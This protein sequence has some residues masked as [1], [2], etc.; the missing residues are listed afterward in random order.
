MA[1]ME[2]NGSPVQ[3]LLVLRGGDIL[4]GASDG[5]IRCWQAFQL[6]STYKGHSDTVR[7]AQDL[8]DFLPHEANF[9]CLQ[10]LGFFRCWQGFQLA[11]TYEGYSDT[12]KCALGS[13]RYCPMR[14]QILPVPG[15]APGGKQL[16]A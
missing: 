11:S 15:P 7:C 16:Q 8:K 9:Q 14:P 5:I 1:T 12:V 10:A 2:H 4:T 3:C 13:N 6:A